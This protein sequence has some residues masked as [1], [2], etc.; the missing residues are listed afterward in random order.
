MMNRRDLAVG[1]I[2]TIGT[3]TMGTASL[4]FGVEAFAGSPSIYG[5]LPMVLFF[6]W[7]AMTAFMIAIDITL[8]INCIRNIRRQRMEINNDIALDPESRPLVVS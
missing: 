6:I 5:Q 1:I 8:T 7:T 3:I 2:M 4:L